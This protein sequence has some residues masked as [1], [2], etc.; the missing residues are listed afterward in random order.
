[1][2]KKRSGFLTKFLSICFLTSVFLIFCGFLW[3]IWIFITDPIPIQQNL[4]I[5]VPIQQQYPAQ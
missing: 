2:A 4:S 3:F 1:M 5:T